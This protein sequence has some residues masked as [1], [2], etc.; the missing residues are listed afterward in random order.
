MDDEIVF[1][2]FFSVAGQFEVDAGVNLFDGHFGV[3]V[4]EGDAVRNEELLAAF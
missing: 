1:E 4:Y 3:T 2:T